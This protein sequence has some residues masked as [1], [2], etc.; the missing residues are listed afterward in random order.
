MCSHSKPAKCRACRSRNIE[1][2][3]RQTQT[4][5]GISGSIQCM[6]CDKQ[7]PLTVNHETYESAIERATLL[8]NR[9][10]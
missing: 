1:F 2:V 4:L 8:W 5:G 9:K 3:D 10:N 6:D 7:G